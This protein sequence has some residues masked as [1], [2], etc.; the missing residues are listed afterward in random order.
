MFAVV[1]A[2]AFGLFAAPQR[3]YAY[4]GNP[5][6]QGPNYSPQRHAAMQHAM[7]TVDFAAWKGLMQG[8]GRVTELVNKSNFPTFARIH[9]LT[10]QGKTQEAETLRKELGLGMRNGAGQGRWMK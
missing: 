6:I 4:R 3:V 1:A 8:K 7:E 5:A 10:L 9:A 2:A